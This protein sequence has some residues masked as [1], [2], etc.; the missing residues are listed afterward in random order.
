MKEMKLI[1]VRTNKEIGD[2]DNGRSIGDMRF[3][4]S[5]RET[6]TVKHHFKIL[7]FLG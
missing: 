2:G 1:R 7:N 6:F 4:N 5:K 3:S